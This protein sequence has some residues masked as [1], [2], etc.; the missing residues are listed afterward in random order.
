MHEHGMLAITA[1]ELEALAAPGAAFSL[2]LS[3]VDRCAC[4]VE[5]R[6][7]ALLRDVH[8]DPGRAAEMADA[9]LVRLRYSNAERKLVT[10]LIRH[11]VPPRDALGAPA[12][13]RR[14]LRRIGPELHPAACQ[15]E[16]AH[17]LALGAADAELHALA[18]F[19]GRAKGELAKNPPLSLSA[20]AI[21]GKRLM[22]DVGLRPGRQI[23]VVL[24]AL[25]ERVLDDPSENE[26]ARLVKH[27]Q[28]LAAA[29]S[30]D[31]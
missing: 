9:L 14:W 11:P 6:L 5:L 15:L 25:L 23:G 19:E 12:S 27:A 1:P 18:E 2:A 3:R 7:G 24:E 10:H 20:L 13:V 21:D 26:P 17:L 29:S 4:E 8:V 22:A 31:R 30:P 28:A 16:R